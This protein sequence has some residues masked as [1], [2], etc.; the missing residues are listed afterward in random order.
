[1]V[2]REITDK[3]TLTEFQKNASDKL[4][5]REKIDMLDAQGNSYGFSAQE[6]GISDFKRMK[7]NYDLYNNIL[8]M[9]DFEY[10]CQPF[11]AEAGEL[12][13]TMT[14]RDISSPRIKALLGM[15]MKRGFKY[16]IIATNREATTRIEEEQFGRINDYVVAEIVRPIKERIEADVLQQ[17]K[18]KKLSP[19]EQEQLKQQIA[20]QIEAE[21]PD[22]VKR[23]MERDHQ[24]PAEVLA[25]HILNQVTREQEL[26][27]MFNRGWLHALLSAYEFYYVGMKGKKAISRELNP[28]RLKYEKGPDEVFIQKSEWVSYDYRVMPSEVVQM[29]GSE[30]NDE[31][32]NE[33]YSNYKYYTSETNVDRLFDFSINDDVDE[34]NGNSLSLKHFCWRALRKIGFLTYLDK[35]GKEQ[36]MIVDENYSLDLEAGD[37]RIEWEWIPQV[38]EGWKLHDKYLGMQMIDS[39]DI[40]IDS[41]Y[42][43]NLPYY[44]GIYDNLNSQ[45]TCPMDRMKHFQYYHNIVMYR[46][47]LLLA[48]DDGKKVLMNINAIPESAGIDI[49]TWQYFFK[50]TNIGWFNPNEEGVGYSDINS[51]AKEVDLSTA[52]DIDKYINLAMYLDKKCGQA[53][54]V[55]DPVL[56]EI[57]P[58]QEVGNTRQ[59]LIQTSHIL[60]PYFN[61]HNQIKRDVTE[62]LLDIT[63]VAWS[64]NPPEYL[65]Y[66]LDDLSRQL[67]NVDEG[68]LKNSKYGL[69]VENSSKSEET[70]EL[71]RQLAHAAMQ[72]EKAELSDVIAVI[73]QDGIQESEE[74]L[75]VAEKKRIDREDKNNQAERQS[76]ERIQQE[77]QDWEREKMA[78]EHSNKMEEIREKG[79]IDLQ[80]QAMLSIGFNE[81]K[82][83]DGDGEIDVLEIYK[84]AQ[85]AEITARTLALDENKFE[86]EKRSN[87]VNE[88]LK[89]KEISVKNKQKSK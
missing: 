50:S 42:D 23:Y 1:M 14:N 56:G 86:E 81:N 87:R 43:Q 2:N 69:F 70:R 10:V 59:Q 66:V 84:N 64:E 33:I 73:R 39:M 46:L 31:E 49:E 26:E 72:T 9:E 85:N 60:E 83:A 36:M 7:V 80:K 12:P 35:V 29:F 4:W 41:I 34:L 55:T 27:D 38:Y 37:L 13:A 24:D 58:S 48:S 78:T 82:D 5:Y 21:T 79:K 61:F 74:I 63:R 25:Q 77:A 89:E 71:I 62:A 75:K 22:K 68:L 47:E 88:K 8:N 16:K 65:N 45:A 57:S 3:Q 19:Q 44:G 40:D 11:G 20:Q 17:T 32:I 15:E 52:S 18:G 28:I 53:V 67:L 30:L 54:G 76:K 6:N 51:M